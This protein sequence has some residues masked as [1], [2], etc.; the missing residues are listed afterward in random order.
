MAT[1]LY[2]LSKHLPKSLL[3][4]CDRE[5]LHYQ[6]TQLAMAGINEIVLAAGHLVDQLRDFTAS[7]SGGLR[8]HYSLEPEPR[9]TAGAIAEARD[10]LAGEPVVVL[11]ADILSSVRI[12]DVI[13][14]H[15][16]RERVATVVGFAVD[17]PSRYGLLHVDG[18]ALTGFSEKPEG[19]ISAGQSFINAGIYVL[20]PQVYVDIPIGEKVSIEHQTFPKLIREHGSLTH[21]A[22]EGL[23]LDAGTFE[24]YFQANFTLLARR[25]TGDDDWLW[26]KRDDCAIFK[27]QVFLCTSAQLGEKVDLF[28]RV[29]VMRGASIGRDSR[30]ENCLVLPGASIGE[31]CALNDC[32]ICPGATIA[33]GA[34]LANTVMIKGEEPVPFFPHASQ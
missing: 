1:R 25:Y 32:I 3:P 18:D 11:N 2:P 16:R 29:I 14:E 17:D 4:I 26:G 12:A 31:G 23:W 22:H 27:D 34:I 15:E 7:Y 13:A 5:L 24:S 20:E 28:H 21:F 30:L 6:I 8:F 33:G 9:G 10:F 19:Q